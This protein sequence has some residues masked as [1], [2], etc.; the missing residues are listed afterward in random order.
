M[1]VTPTRSYAL[2]LTAVVFVVCAWIQLYTLPCGDIAWLTFGTHRLLQGDILYRDIIEP[3]PPLIFWLYAIPIYLAQQF[4]WNEVLTLKG[5]VMALA[6]LSLGLVAIILRHSTHYKDAEQRHGLILGIAALLLLG[7]DSFIVFAQRE[8]LLVILMLPYLMMHLPSVD[9]HKPSFSLRFFIGVMAAIGLCLKPYFFLLWFARLA[10]DAWRARSLRKSL[11][12]ADI[13]IMLSC[14]TYGAAIWFFTPD[15]FNWL[16]ILSPIYLSYRYIGETRSDIVIWFIA[17]ALAAALCAR[18]FKVLEAIRREAYGP[19]I[20][21]LSC[22]ATAAYLEALA[23]FKTWGYISYPFMSFGIIVLM[24][25]ILK[26]QLSDFLS[27]ALLAWV[28]FPLTTMTDSRQDLD[29]EGYLLFMHELATVHEAKHLYFLS[30]T[31]AP[32]AFYTHRNKLMWSSRFPMM[33]FLLQGIMQTSPTGTLSMR[34]QP[35]KEPLQRWLWDAM[36]A[37]LQKNQPEVLLLYRMVWREESDGLGFDFYGWMQRDSILSLILSQ[38]HKQAE[39][40]IYEDQARTCFYD[41]YLKLTTP[42]SDY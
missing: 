38:Y 17:I 13:S 21:Y 12:L 33:H 4:G 31:F 37:D 7:A 18:M 14:V 10:H 42:P 35:G 9:R 6:A 24:M 2:W 25:I 41:L 32:P 15:Y 5:G 34:I 20:A 29:R 23:Q 22:L 36:A 26:R 27:F 3:N 28:F 19:D 11:G 8:H 30:P 40:K 16:S 39:I 1:I